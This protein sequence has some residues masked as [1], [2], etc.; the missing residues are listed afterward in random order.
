[1]GGARAGLQR[2]ALH[3]LLDSRPV[4]R[5]AFVVLQRQR[6]GGLSCREAAREARP[7][8]GGDGSRGAPHVAPVP[9]DR[10]GPDGSQGLASA[11]AAAGRRR[12]HHG[13]RA[14]PRVLPR[15]AFAGRARAVRRRGP[16]SG[17]AAGELGPGGMRSPAGRRETASA[18][19]AASAS[20]TK[21]GPAS[22]G[23][24]SCAATS[25]MADRRRGVAA[26]FSAHVDDCEESEEACR[27]PRQNRESGWKTS[28]V[29]PMMSGR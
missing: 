26:S 6:G 22:A 21:P 15:G 27:L 19:S 18:I 5:V 7:H 29:P 24:K 13:P 3:R 14:H 8:S 17:E 1:M 20:C 28:W 12:F 2:G 11:A 4:P 10:E 16:R 25:R 9:L 23:W